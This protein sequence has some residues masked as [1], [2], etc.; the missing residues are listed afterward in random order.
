[1]EFTLI[2]KADWEQIF[3]DLPSGKQ[4]CGDCRVAIAGTQRKH[5]L[6]E[7]EALIQKQIS[8]AEEQG[9]VY[10]TLVFILHELRKEAGL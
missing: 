5:T 8:L 2:D 3:N 1:M 4:T 6:K 7:V 10:S 9:E